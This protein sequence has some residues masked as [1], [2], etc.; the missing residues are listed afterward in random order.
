MSM[1]GLLGMLVAF[2]IHPPASMRIASE[3]CCGRAVVSRVGAGGLR[4]RLKSSKTYVA[5]LAA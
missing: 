4:A 3:F 2:E 5:R 1:S